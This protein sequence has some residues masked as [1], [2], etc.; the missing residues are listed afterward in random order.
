MHKL[1]FTSTHVL[2]VN[3]WEV[4][5]VFEKLIHNCLQIKTS[6]INIFHMMHVF[7]LVGFRCNITDYYVRWVGR[8]VFR[9]WQMY[10]CSAINIASTRLR[11]SITW[12]ASRDVLQRINVSKSLTSS[13][14]ITNRLSC[15]N[16]DF[17]N[18]VR[19]ADSSICALPD[20]PQQV[21]KE[22]AS[23]SRLMFTKNLLHS[24]SEATRKKSC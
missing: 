16:E 9:R 1:T 24:P 5:S 3:W 15:R 18:H 4:S 20:Q 8:L 2:C 23:I 7:M 14:G 13:P 17:K 11:V 21:N 10:R 19:V 12:C 6:S 22:K